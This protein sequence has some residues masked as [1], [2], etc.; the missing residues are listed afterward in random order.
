[1]R[2]S[3]SVLNNSPSSSFYSTLYTKET[4][5]RDWKEGLYCCHNDFNTDKVCNSANPPLMGFDIHM[6]MHCYLVTRDIFFTSSS[7]R[8]LRWKLCSKTCFDA[9]GE[10]RIDQEIQ[11]E[12][13]LVF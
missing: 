6:Y 7:T 3:D 2:A 4:S 11:S 12:L 10:S 13:C 9:V 5:L 8:S 1:M